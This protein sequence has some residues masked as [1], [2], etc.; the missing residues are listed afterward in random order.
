MAIRQ[1]SF[2]AHP[3]D[4]PELARQAQSSKSRVLKEAQIKLAEAQRA[5][6]ALR[7]IYAWVEK[8][9]CQLFGKQRTEMIC[10][11]G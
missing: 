8:R 4:I 6:I 7:P 1:P 11:L 3:D 9:E 2:V 10:K 5:D